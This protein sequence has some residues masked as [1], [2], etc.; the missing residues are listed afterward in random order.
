M[1]GRRVAELMLFKR[2]A[3]RRAAKAEAKRVRPEVERAQASMETA[4]EEINRDLDSLPGGGIRC[5]N[6]GE[7]LI[8]KRNRWGQ[9]YWSCPRCYH[10]E[11]YEPEATA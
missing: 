4:L 10:T 11:N 9:N 3:F 8:L 6:H 7:L 5:P 1:R 2:R